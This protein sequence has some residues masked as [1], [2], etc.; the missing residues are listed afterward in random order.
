MNRQK[1]ARLK[2]ERRIER[3]IRNEYLQGHGPEGLDLM[4]DGTW[5]ARCCS[6]DQQYEWY[7]MAIEYSEDMSYCGRSERCCP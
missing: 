7:A 4:K 6:C 2:R 3:N 1:E 5:S